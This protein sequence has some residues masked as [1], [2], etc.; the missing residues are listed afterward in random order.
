MKPK[1][2]K[3]LLRL[4]AIA[5]ITM[6]TANAE[7][8][9][10]TI[11]D[12][13]S[14]IGSGLVSAG[15]GLA[16]L[17]GKALHS[18]DDSLPML[19]RGTQELGISGNVNFNDDVAYNL[20]FSYGY[21]FKDNWEVGFTA[22]A[23]G[24][25]DFNLGVGLFTEYN[26]GCRS[27]W[28]PYIG[29]AVKWARVDTDNFNRDAI[30]FTG[31]LGVKYFIRSHMAVFAAINYEWSPDDVFGIGDEIKDSASNIN[32]GMRFYF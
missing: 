7:G 14:A 15:R 1:N 20:D 32:F 18:G 4:F 11:G 28:V 8:I 23:F 3:Q 22:N 30:A 26:F 9:A 31:E 19:S 21:F 5:S 27:K 29:F 2:T 25:D 12:T 13:T 16:S 24:E 6:G 17:P 10:S